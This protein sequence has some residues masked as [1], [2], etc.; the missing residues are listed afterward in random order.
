M[1]QRP[2]IEAA[3]ARMGSKFGAKRELKA[4]PDELLENETVHHIVSGEYSGG[5]GI[6][7][8]TDRR[9]LFVFRGIMKQ[10]TEDFGYNRISSIEYNGGMLLG[11]IKVYVSNQKA[12]I[13]NLQKTEA[14]RIVDDVRAFMNKPAEANNAP[15]PAPSSVHDELMKLKKL[16]E[17]GILDDATYE[18]KSKPL[19]E[20]L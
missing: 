10:I 20:Q 13:K 2:D 17:A 8:A 16:H 7:V 12:E 6:L 1:T 4:L 5:L 15:A 9:L 18:A 11:G 19:I 3:L 14:K